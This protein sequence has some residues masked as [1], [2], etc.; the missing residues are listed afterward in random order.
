[1]FSR[2]TDWFYE[3]C[4]FDSRLGQEIYRGSIMTRRVLGPFEPSIQWGTGGS[5]PKLKPPRHEAS[6][7]SLFSA[8]V[9]NECSCT[10]TPP[11]VFTIC[12]ETP[13]PLPPTAFLNLMNQIFCLVEKF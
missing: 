10:S 7:S 5:L 8:K 9:K 13:V 6:Y 11:D 1:M 12:A 4:R 3:Q 2:A